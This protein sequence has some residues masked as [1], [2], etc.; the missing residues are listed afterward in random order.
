MRMLAGI[1]LAAASLAAP[2]LQAEPC[3][4]APQPTGLSTRAGYVEFMPAPQL[5]PFL[6]ALPRID[7]PAVDA[8]L[9]SPDTMWYDDK[10]M[11][12]SYQDSEEFVVGLRANCVGR[13]I[14][15]MS[16][17]QPQVGKLLQLFGPDYRFDY[18]F[19]TAAG[20]DGGPNVRALNFWVP[21]RGVDGKALPVR[22]WKTSARGR[23]RWLFP[24]GT[25]LGEVL[26]EVGPDGRLYPFEVRTRQRY[27]DG[28]SV[29]AYR[30]F[31][32]AASLSA[33]V[34]N[35]R[36]NWPQNAA[37]SDLIA[38]LDDPNTLVETRL[39]AP[40][41]AAVF[42][43][44]TGALDKLPPFGDDALVEEL[45]QGQ[46][47]QSAEGAIW[48]ENG[49]LETYAASS[50]AAFSIVP[51]D[52]TIGVVPVN[53]DGCNRCHTAT[54]AHL[55]TFISD[56]SAYG[57]VWG[58]DRIFT[59]HLFEPREQIY[60]PWDDNQGSRALNPRL[61]SAGLVQS[62]KPGAQD[63]VYRELPPAP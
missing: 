38:H 25:V 12:F 23:W 48:K 27:L 8:L 51:K 43:P 33:A 1:A 47:F 14:A 56:V 30:P 31:L 55:G 58:E 63:P 15:E 22:W 2:R 21:P 50:S 18:P 32:T 6:A 4:Y 9:R 20:T 3:Q 5:A 13:V 29:A 53:E 54:G 59:W 39:T 45:L 37:L 42:P 7:D 61:V 16:R 10:S 41:F 11:V 52:Y 44:M 19:R 49:T 34:K 57:E 40:V 26:F 60:G 62:G 35:A 46:T 24:K 36:P 28:W 17:D